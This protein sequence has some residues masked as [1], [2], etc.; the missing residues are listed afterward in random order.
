MLALTA[1]SYAIIASIPSFLSDRSI[2]EKENRRKGTHREH[3]FFS[4]PVTRELLRGNF[5][6]RR[7][8]VLPENSQAISIPR[9]RKITAE[10][11]VFACQ[12][13]R[14]IVHGC[15]LATGLREG[16]QRGGREGVRRGARLSGQ[17]SPESENVE[18]GPR[19]SQLRGLYSSARLLLRATARGPSDYANHRDPPAT[20]DS[21]I[22]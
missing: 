22:R 3:A 15:V 2:F 19:L 12:F 8:A 4:W 14:L 10:Q 5:A 1:E 17:R 6:K 20:I 7:R 11:P 21:L 18:P 16:P 13:S 9:N